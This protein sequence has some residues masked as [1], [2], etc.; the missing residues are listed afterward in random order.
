MDGVLP[1]TGPTAMPLCFCCPTRTVLR[2]AGTSLSSASLSRTLPAIASGSSSGASATRA[3]GSPPW[4]SA[5][6][7][8]SCDFHSVKP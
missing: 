6:S 1:G 4:S 7:G 8:S 5:A 3:P 2:F